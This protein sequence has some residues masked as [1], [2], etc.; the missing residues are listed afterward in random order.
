MI[1]VIP[2]DT[3]ISQATISKFFNHFDQYKEGYIELERFMDI[4]YNFSKEE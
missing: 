3:I 4:F 1:A 2:R